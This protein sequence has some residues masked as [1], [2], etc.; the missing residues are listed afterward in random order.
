MLHSF[1]WEFNSLLNDVKNW[2]SVR[3]WQSYGREFSGLLFWP[4]LYS[5]TSVDRWRATCQFATRPSTCVSSSSPPDTV[6]R[7]TRLQSS[8]RPPRVKVR[9]PRWS[10]EACCTRGIGAGFSSTGPTARWA[11]TAAGRTRQSAAVPDTACRSTT[12]ST[13]S[14]IIYGQ[15]AVRHLTSRSASRPAATA[16]TWSHRAPRCLGSGSMWL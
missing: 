15:S 13:C 6:S 7:T 9:C 4:T 8:S 11:G 14:S 5:C 12:S 1:C 10:G 16:S 3:I 2:K